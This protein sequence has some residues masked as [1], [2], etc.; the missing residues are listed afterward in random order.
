[1]RPVL[2]NLC[3]YESLIDGSIDLVD[4]ARMNDALDVQDEN[5]ARYREATKSNG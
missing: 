4:V 3:R 2:R 1:M 5:A